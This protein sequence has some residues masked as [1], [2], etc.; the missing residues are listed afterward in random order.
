A[1][2]KGVAGRAEAAGDG[3]VDLVSGRVRPTGRLGEGLG[4]LSGSS[5][6]VATFVVFFF[7]VTSFL[8]ADFFLADFDFAPGLGDFFGFGFTDS[9]EVAFGFGVAS[10]S[11]DA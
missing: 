11:S 7:G 1:R 6:S 5:S 4:V 8:A 3:D 9:S 2:G 10:S